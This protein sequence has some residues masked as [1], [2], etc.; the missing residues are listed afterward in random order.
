MQNKHVR[1]A[2]KSIGDQ[3]QQASGPFQA[4]SLEEQPIWAG[5]VDNLREALFPPHLPPL[6]LTSTPIP[7]Q[8]RMA[9]KT[10]PWAI[11]TATFM[12]AALL[13]L[14]ILLGL[15]A[16]ISHFPPRPAWNRHFPQRLHPLSRR[17]APTPRTEAWQW[18]LPRPHRPHHGPR[19]PPH[20]DIPL[21]PPQ[22]PV[23]R[24]PAA[25][26]RTGHLPFRSTSSSPT[27]RR[28]QISAC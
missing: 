21:S 25:H 26:R 18:R 8:D 27:T 12:N 23:H 4:V 10:N 16:P 20:V 17:P 1:L 9:G 7:T 28:S 3:S 24:P 15:R 22:V 19:T 2:E 6:E 5:L 14:I 11:G 13:A